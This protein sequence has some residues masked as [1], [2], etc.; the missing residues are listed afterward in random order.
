MRTLS[1]KKAPTRFFLLLIPALLLQLIGSLFYFIFF[2]GTEFAQPVYSLTKLLLL[3]YPL[4]WLYF[5]QP[6]QK[7]NPPHHRQ[8]IIKGLLF[9]ILASLLIMAVYF[10]FQD[11]FNQF[12]PQLIVQASSL[13]ILR[14]YALFALFLSVFHSLF[15][16]YYWRWFIFRALQTKYSFRTSAFISSAAFASHHFI[17]TS[18]FFPVHLAALFTIAVMCGGWFWSYLYAKNG[19]LIG[20]WISHICIDIAIL[21]AGYMIIFP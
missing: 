18:Q 2:K 8:S 21:T 16:E 4:L 6:L 12:Q 3:I 17:I 1:I 10:S 20:P 19:S 7:F 14:H 5:K 9:G 13:K 15:E 11:Y